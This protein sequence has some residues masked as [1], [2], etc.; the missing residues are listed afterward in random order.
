MV[1]FSNIL[2]AAFPPIFLCHKRIK[3]NFKYKKSCVYFSGTKILSFLKIEIQS[4]LCKTITFG[5]TK[6]W[7]LLSGGRCS[8]FIYILKLKMGPENG[9]RYEQ[10]V[11]IRR[12][13]LAQV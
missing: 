10:V 8:E 1:N 13:S 6:K 9:G 5:T 11:A 2:R 3:L 12:W 4:N 7:P